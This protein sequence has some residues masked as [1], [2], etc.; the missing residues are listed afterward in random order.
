MDFLVLLFRLQ[1][2]LLLGFQLTEKLLHQIFLFNVHCPH[3]D[4]RMQSVDD[5][6]R[7][8][9]LAHFF[10][11]VAQVLLSC[12]RRGHVEIDKILSCKLRVERPQVIF[13]LTLIK[14]Q[15]IRICLQFEYSSVSH[16]ELKLHFE[17]EVL[18][19]R[20]Y[21]FCLLKLAVQVLYSCTEHVQRAL[22]SL[23]IL[24]LFQLSCS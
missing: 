16:V 5:L 24:D 3:N 18:I 13:E 17:N 6:S 9:Y 1:S 23:Q 20:N 21:H 7:F 2:H 14:P 12:V 11:E 15:L 8:A 22:G 4:L 10:Q 19:L